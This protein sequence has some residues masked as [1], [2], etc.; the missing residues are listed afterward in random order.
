MTGSPIAE[1]FYICV[2]L[3]RH[4]SPFCG[5]NVKDNAIQ[6]NFNFQSAALNALW[7]AAN[8]TTT[9]ATVNRYFMQFIAYDSTI[10]IG[11]DGIIQR[12]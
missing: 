2:S 10:S 1:R 9:I 3:Q 7:G 6:P 5:V 11:K 4:N 12:R 8:N